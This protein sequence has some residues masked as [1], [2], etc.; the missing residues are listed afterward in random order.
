MT[1]EVNTRALK[2]LDTHHVV[3][4]IS[5]DPASKGGHPV[6]GKQSPTGTSAMSRNCFV[7]DNT[8]QVI[9]G[10]ISYRSASSSDIVLSQKTES[11]M[12][13]LLEA[14]SAVWHT[15]RRPSSWILSGRSS[16]SNAEVSTVIDVSETFPWELGHETKESGHVGRSLLFFGMYSWVITVFEWVLPF[17][18]RPQLFLV[19]LVSS[20]DS[21]PG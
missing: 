12:T 14:G 18:W 6:P 16:F 20:R 3:S 10:K 19:D 11:S 8:W 4:I 7:D 5:P 9:S 13:S 17:L 21:S 2:V 1:T 15:Y